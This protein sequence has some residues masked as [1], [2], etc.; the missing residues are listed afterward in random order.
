MHWHDADGLSADSRAHDLADAFEGEVVQAYI[1][2]GALL[3]RLGRTRRA[4]LEWQAAPGQGD[5]GVGVEGDHAAGTRADRLESCTK[6]REAWKLNLELAFNMLT[7][8]ALPRSPTSARRA[9]WPTTT[10]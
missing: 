2:E 9:T 10:R 5:V 6:Q 8:V 1:N 7:K 3:P 4:H